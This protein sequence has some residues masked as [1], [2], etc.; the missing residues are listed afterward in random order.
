MSK[1]FEVYGRSDI[2]KQ[3]QQ[4]VQLLQNWLWAFSLA[5]FAVHE[6]TVGYRGI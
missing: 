3:Q 4:N 2:P 1:E 5:S 6:V